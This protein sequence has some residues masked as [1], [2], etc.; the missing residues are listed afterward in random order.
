MSLEQK[1]ICNPVDRL[2]VATSTLP[3][4]NTLYTKG[5]LFVNVHIITIKAL[6]RQIVDTKHPS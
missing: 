4:A 5:M 3:V 2:I 6:S 1:I